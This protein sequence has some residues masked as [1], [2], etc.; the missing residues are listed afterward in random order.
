MAIQSV[1][2]I[3]V[4]PQAATRGPRTLPTGSQLRHTP[5]ATPTRSCVNRLALPT[6]KYHIEIQ[7]DSLIVKREILF[8]SE[9]KAG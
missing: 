5:D 9:P 1:K 7:A 6:A 2:I 3:R 4:I 8:L